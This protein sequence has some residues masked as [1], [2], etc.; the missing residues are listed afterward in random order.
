MT[1]RVNFKSQPIKRKCIHFATTMHNKVHEREWRG[2]KRKKIQREKK[3]HRAT[4]LSKYPE[5]F[6]LLLLSLFN[7]SPRNR[8]RHLQ[9]LDPFRKNLLHTRAKCYK[10]LCKLDLCFKQISPVDTEGLLDARREASKGQRLQLTRLANSTR[11][12]N[13]HTKKRDQA[14]EWLV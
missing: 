1:K 5:P 3:V 13:R 8:L 10:C 7:E 14:L 6:A 2:K 11:W 12:A 9:T 4:Q